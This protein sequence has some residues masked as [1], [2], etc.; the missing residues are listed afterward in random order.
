MSNITNLQTATDEIKQ[1]AREIYYSLT[2][3][4]LDHPARANLTLALGCLGVSRPKD[5]GLSEIKPYHKA[6][7]SSVYDGPMGIFEGME[8]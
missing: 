4:E 1:A 3:L 2:Y 7:S 6:T 5:V 8:D